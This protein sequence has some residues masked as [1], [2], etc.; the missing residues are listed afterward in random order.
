[1]V[2]K[3]Q[4]HGLPHEP[5]SRRGGL[6]NLRSSSRQNFGRGGHEHTIQNPLV[7]SFCLERFADYLLIIFF[8]FVGSRL[9]SVDLFIGLVYLFL[10][11]VDFFGC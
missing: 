5:P 8:F 2:S 10:F 7:C 6:K 9:L 11:L 4:R 1:M 3:E